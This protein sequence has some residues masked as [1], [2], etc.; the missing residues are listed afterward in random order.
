MM[1]L[2]EFA[3]Q[4]SNI[5]VTGT[6]KTRLERE[7]NIR[8]GDPEWFQLWFSLPK[9]MNGERAVGTGYRGIKNEN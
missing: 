1:R 4:G 2:L 6:E 7:L 8:P 5:S 3:I 9:F